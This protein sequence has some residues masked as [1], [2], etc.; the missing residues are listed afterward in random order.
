L[1]PGRPIEPEAGYGEYHEERAQQVRRD[2]LH[3][4][5]E[6]EVGMM[7]ALGLP[8]G[9]RLPLTIT[10]VTDTHVTLDANHPLAGRKLAF[11]IELVEIRK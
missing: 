3:L 5:G 10:E 11:D 2:G 6:P 7:V 4:E 9:S 8:D 1:D